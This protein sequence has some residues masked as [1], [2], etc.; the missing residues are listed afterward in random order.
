MRHLVFSQDFNWH[1]QLDTGSYHYGE[2]G[3]LVMDGTEADSVQ[4]SHPARCSQPR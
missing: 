3:Y 4:P 1:T 2:N